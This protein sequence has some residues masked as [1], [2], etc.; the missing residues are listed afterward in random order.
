MAFRVRAAASACVVASGLFMAGAGGAIALADPGHGSGGADRSDDGKG[1][2]SIGDIVR[3]AFG[4]G[5]GTDEKASGPG[6][7]GPQTRWGNG[8]Q[9]R[10]PG[11][12]QPPKTETP[13]TK[14]E[15]PPTK[16]ETPPTKTPCPEPTETT[17]PTEPT[18]PPGSPP[19]NPPQSPGSGGGGAIPPPP[20]RYRPPSPPGMQLPNEQLPGQPGAAGGSDVL[21]AGA[22]IAAAAVP[23][24]VAAPIALPVIVVPPIALPGVA[25]GAGLG[26]GASAGAPPAVPRA[27]T[28]QPPAGRVPPPA[29]VGSN[30]AAPNSSYRIGYTEYL[31][32][33]GLPQVAALAVPGL[34]GIMVLTGAGGLLGY[35][36]AKAGHAVH[37]SG[38]ARYIR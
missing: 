3:G 21:D 4:L 25:A 36:Q 28:A 24:G 35:R 27:V 22:G 10:H 20:P 18:P 8:R 13:P 9:G 14:T 34:V 32:S 6:Q 23:A 2:G 11:G 30:V 16:T 33:A 19:P 37:V 7:Q 26:G 15:T 5:D 1:D 38:S 29:N 17:E 12:T 31:R